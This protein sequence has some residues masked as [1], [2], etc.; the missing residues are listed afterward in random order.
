[1]G[2]LG[3]RAMEVRIGLST[4]GEQFLSEMLNGVSISELAV[5]IDWRTLTRLLFTAVGL[6]VGT[7]RTQ[8]AFQAA[9]E[10]SSFR[11]QADGGWGTT[12]DLAR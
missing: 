1:M 8:T 10:Q 6:R 11:T 7:S 12:A 5:S 3:G 4:A 9:L 2:G